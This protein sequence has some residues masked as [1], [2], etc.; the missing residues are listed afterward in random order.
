MVQGVIEPSNAKYEQL[1]Q[2]NKELRTQI[3]KTQLEAKAEIISLK[4]ANSD[5]TKEIEMLKEALRQNG[6]ELPMKSS[7]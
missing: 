7:E 5:L 2:E 6:I 3:A 4:Q 1:K